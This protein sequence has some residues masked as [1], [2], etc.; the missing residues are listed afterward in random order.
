LGY[1]RRVQRPDQGELNPFADRSDPLNLSTGNPGL[2]PEYI[3]LVELGHQKSFENKATLATTAFYSVESQTIKSFRQVIA[4]PLTG[5][6]V[7]ST[8]RINLGD[9]IN[10]G[11]EVVGSLP[12]AAFWKVSGSASAFRRIIQGSVA[13]TDITNANFVY[14]SR[15]NTTITPVKKLDVQVSLNYRSPVVTAQGRRQ[16][17]VNVD[18]AAK[19]TF[20]PQDRGTLTLRVSDVFNTLRYNFNAYGPGLDAVSYNKRE[21]R[22]GFLN[23]SYR[24]GRDG[25]AAKPRKEEKEAGGGFE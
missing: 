8:T 9:E 20:L 16:T 21:S 6:Q 3:D 11:L 24:F 14:T 25:E 19:Y 23:F 4:D 7:T 10:Y 12:L 17:A 18:A 13:N 1:S 15:I 5:N 2:L 22:V